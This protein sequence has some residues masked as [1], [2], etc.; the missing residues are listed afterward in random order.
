MSNDPT[1]ASID[2]AA[3][4]ANPIL[5]SPYLPPEAY[6]QIGPAGPTGT[7]LKGRRP[8][9]SF[10][11]IPVPKKGRTAANAAAEFAEQTEIDFDVAGERRE[12][13]SLIN[14]VRRDVELWRVR[15]YPG[16]TPYTRKLLTH[17]AAYPR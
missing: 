10:I 13:N 7:I 8:S 11:P 2:P 12:N 5:N 4:L 1:L 17:W 9:L 3:A 16:V 14:D 6:F 15:N